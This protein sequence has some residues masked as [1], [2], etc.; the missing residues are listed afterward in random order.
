[1]Q[2]AKCRIN[3]ETSQQKRGLA[4]AERSEDVPVPAFAAHATPPEFSSLLGGPKDHGQL[5]YSVERGREFAPS[6]RPGAVWR[7]KKVKQFDLLDVNIV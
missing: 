4:Q 5:F 6:D 1:M 7:K 2:N 3:N